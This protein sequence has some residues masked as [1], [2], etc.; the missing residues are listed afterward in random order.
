MAQEKLGRPI[1]AGDCGGRWMGV[2]A[3]NIAE[4]EGPDDRVLEFAPPRGAVE[5]SVA[6]EL[7][8]RRRAIDLSW[9][10]S[11]PPLLIPTLVEVAECSAPEQREPAPALMLR[12]VVQ[13][14]AALAE[15][16]Q[17]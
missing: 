5:R 15:R 16:L 1:V 11:P 13:H 10:R 12:P 7:R 14:V 17:V 8:K 6:A 9:W 2:P 3:G 4:E